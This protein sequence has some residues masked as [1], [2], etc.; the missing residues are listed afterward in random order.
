MNL[1]V[2]YSV[3]S[4]MPA[5]LATSSLPV[6]AGVMAVTSYSAGA[7]F[8]SLLQGPLMARYPSRWLFAVELGAFIGFVVL[9]ATAPLSTLLVG[10]TAFAIGW[11]IQGAQAGLN[12]FSA[13]FYP[14]AV[15]STGI[16]WILGVGRIGSILGPILAGMA[17]QAQ[18]T[19]QQIFLAGGVPAACAAIALFVAASRDSPETTLPITGESNAPLKVS[20]ESASQVRT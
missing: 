8:G 7:V 12:A 1:L 2:L 16:G 11:A 18:W 19:S 5:L 17:L 9:L 3:I 20:R 4:W 13:G 15:R 14:A 6:S 10:C